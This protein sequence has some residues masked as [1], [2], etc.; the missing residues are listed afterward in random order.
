MGTRRGRPL[1]SDEAFEFHVH[2]RLRRGEDDDLIAF[3]ERTP[4]RKRAGALKTALRLG[5]LPAET[6]DDGPSDEDLAEALDGLLL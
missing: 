1:A 4:L 5:A 6:V 3:F 2:L